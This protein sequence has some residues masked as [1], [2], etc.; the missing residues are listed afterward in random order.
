MEDLEI[1]DFNK[2]TNADKLREIFGQN[3]SIQSHPVMIGDIQV[4]TYT[5]LNNDLEQKRIEQ[6]LDEEY[7]SVN[8]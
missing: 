1:I 4:K 7:K 5:I 8:S 2:V 3:F 6:W